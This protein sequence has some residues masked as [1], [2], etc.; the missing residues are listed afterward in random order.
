MKKINNQMKQ[1]A[2]KGLVAFLIIMVGFTGISRAGDSMTVPKVE[3]VTVKPGK[4]DKK[5]E[6][7][8]VLQPKEEDSLIVGE[9]LSV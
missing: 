4:I 7:T 1:T 5:I 2:Q 3:I 8:G 6:G 9:G